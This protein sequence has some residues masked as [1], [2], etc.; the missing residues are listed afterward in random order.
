LSLSL[1]YIFINCIICIFLL[2]SS[3]Y[4]QNLKSTDY[5]QLF[6]I[7][8]WDKEYKIAKLQSESSD[9]WQYYNLAYSLDANISMYLA[10]D[11]LIYLDRTLFYINNMINS[12]QISKNIE[13]SQYKDNFLGWPNHTAPSKGNDGKEYPLF[14]SFCWRY[15]TFLLFKMSNSK[16]LLLE[17]YR[18]NYNIILNFTEKNIFEKWQSRGNQ[19]LYRGN[20]HMTSHW[21]R[22]SLNLYFITHKE[23]YKNF[24]HNFYKMF[25]KHS[26]VLNNNTIKWNIFWDNKDNSPQDISHGN[27]VV[28]TIID[29]YEKRY[30]FNK[31]DLDILINTFK[32]SVCQNNKYYSKYID[33]TG[34][35]SGWFNDGFIILGKYNKEIQFCLE[36]QLNAKSTQY[37]AN[38]ALNSKN[39]D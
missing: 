36:Q 16:I 26:I 37:F 1:K 13:S 11:S 8:N 35:G 25:K 21:A 17:K 9:S 23:K 7:Q 20:V 10:T 15:V 29:Y 38:M 2:K 27:A 39:F 6:F 34:I 30:L 3:I 32:I 22:I 19:N 28:S 33:G 24:A 12:A 31:Y 4:A 14:E 5:W 18:I